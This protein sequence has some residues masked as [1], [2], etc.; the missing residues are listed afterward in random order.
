M[1]RKLRIAVLLYV[2]LVVALTTW[3]ARVRNTDWNSPLWVVI[4]PINGEGNARTADYIRTLSE[5]D[6]ESIETVIRTEAAGWHIALNQP[7]V[8]KLAPEV[9]SIPP[10]PP[11][12]RNPLAVGWWSL[13]LRLWAS[14]NDTF[15][16]PNDIRLYAVYYDPENRRT[17]AHSLGLEKGF[18]G[19]VNGFGDERYTD[20]NNVVLAHEMLHTLG[21]TD[22]YD[23]GTNQAL[24]PSGYAEPDR[25]PLYPQRKAELMGG[26]IPLSRDASKMPK[27]LEETVI[28]PV[29]AFEIGWA[30]SP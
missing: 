5:R 15:E 28:G 14:L 21:A 6:F 13:R 1:W 24:F 29:T 27:A 10:P 18:I 16:G 23:P 26:R 19:V 7:V 25:E 20:T 22:K 3:S 8:V 12:G 9:T 4:Y 17:L 30:R 11:A 2:L